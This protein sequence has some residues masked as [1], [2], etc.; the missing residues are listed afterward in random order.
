MVAAPSDLYSHFHRNSII[1]EGFQSSEE[2]SD[3]HSPILD[4]PYP[5]QDVRYHLGHLTLPDTTTSLV[6]PFDARFPVNDL[7]VQIPDP[8]ILETL[9]VPNST[10]AH[11]S[12]SQPPNHHDYGLP[13]HSLLGLEHHPSRLQL[14]AL[15]P[16]NE[17]SFNITQSRLSEPHLNMSQIPPSNSSRSTHPVPSNERRQQMPSSTSGKGST[18][19]SPG[20]NSTPARPPRR[21]ASTAVIACRQCRA[22]K[23]R[24]DST[25]PVCHNCTRRNNECEYDAVPKRRGPD[26]RPGTRQRS[27]KKRPPESEPSAPQSKKRRK[28]STDH[29]GNVISFDVKE[30]VTGYSKRS[31]SMSRYSSEDTAGLPIS[32]TI[33]LILETSISPRDFAPEAIYPKD[34]LSP[35][36]RRTPLYI[37]HSYNKSYPRQVDMNV[38]RQQEEEDQKTILTSTPSFDY[39]RRTW[40]DNLLDSYS[41]SRE[42]SF[43]EILSDLDFLLSSSSYWLFFINVP[44]FFQQVRDPQ[45]R[46]S[47]QPSLIMSA[48]ALSTLM[49]SSEIERG[50]AGRERALWL[51]D[52][53]ETYMLSAC[54]SQAVDYTLAEAA[55]M[56]ALF[57][58]SCHPL[59]SIARA[60]ESL[61]FVDRII[62]SQSLT[63]TDLA[64]PDTPTY[65]SR[66]IPMIR[67]P[68]E[69]IAP[70]RCGCQNPPSS[71][72]SP[73]SDHFS[74]S[75]SFNPPWDP[76]WSLEEIR[77]E[78]C[79]RI[80]WSALTLVASHTAQCAAFHEEPLELSLANP[81]NYALLFPGEA[82]ERSAEHRIPGQSPKDSIWALYCRSMLLWNSCIRQQDSTWSTD[83]RAKFAID[84]WLETQT[85]QE[86][87]D[88]HQCNLDTA[89]MYVCRE[90]L[91]NTRMTITYELRR[92]LQDIESVGI[93]MFNRRQAQE[94]LHYQNQVGRR[95][96]SSVLQL[97]EAPGH[98]LSR[99]PFQVIWF[100]SQVAICLALWEYDHSLMLALDLA[101]SFLIPLDALNALWPCP[102]QRMR[103]DELR[104][105]LEDACHSAGMTAP[106]PAEV[107]LPPILKS[108]SV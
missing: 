71:P 105:N 96:K 40:W 91:Y 56:I 86:A 98:L 65:T 88:M 10:S 72:I 93:P 66:E 42:Q 46:A 79:R 7:G 60:N 44:L 48:L 87:L 11:Y 104:R 23:I 4:V 75:F 21:E 92:S 38:H 25:R 12:L 64:D 83:E 50:A 39:I 26:K 24:C 20:S 55:I 27:C 33:P 70:Q 59:Y 30:N 52:S 14:P 78:E 76:N 94:W 108:S 37:D 9:Q 85:V 84:A 16:P 67:Y 102:A 19:G 54:N 81:A 63:L 61:Q 3:L 95:V 53:A 5:P 57:E 43:Q 17:F 68:C 107:T 22:R 101:K 90:Y 100:S 58:S 62:T 32:Q 28:T 97:G 18:A 49:R 106:L 6:P 99:R 31:L 77:K 29:D 51:R 73:I 80:C 1:E 2:G 15:S 8:H 34:D 82:Y 47:M 41:S 35:I 103:C 45:Q 89:L 36:T 74:L 69:H 13:Q